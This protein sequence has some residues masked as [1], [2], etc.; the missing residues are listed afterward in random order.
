MVKVNSLNP[1]DKG[2]FGKTM[3]AWAKRDIK[4]SNP[5]NLKM[6][7]IDDFNRH[8]DLQLMAKKLEKTPPSDTFAEIEPP[9]G[10]PNIF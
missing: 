5:S 4:I 2:F 10:I 1:F 6:T 9:T 8:F 3:S 7:S